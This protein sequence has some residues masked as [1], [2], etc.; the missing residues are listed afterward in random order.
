[1]FVFYL[2]S[3]TG[4]ITQRKNQCKS[5]TFHPVG[6]I[7][8]SMNILLSLAAQR[9]KVPWS[10][11]KSQAS[12]LKGSH[13]TVD[14]LKEFGVEEVKMR[15]LRYVVLERPLGKAI[16]CHYVVFLGG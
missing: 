4:M 5:K 11:D 15:A 12:R 2:I 16:Y 9:M 1:M 8:N 10:S 3:V 13:P 14:F 6:K 7:S